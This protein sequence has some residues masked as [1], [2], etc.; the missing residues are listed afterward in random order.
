MA[1]FEV[2]MLLECQSRFLIYLQFPDV[3]VFIL[4]HVYVY[5]QLDDEEAR[6][7]CVSWERL[8]GSRVVHL[9]GAILGSNTSGGTCV[10]K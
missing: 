1:N 6:C 8:V 3:G 4:S 7:V 9:S 5:D 10:A 2:S